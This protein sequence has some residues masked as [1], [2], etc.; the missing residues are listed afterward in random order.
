MHQAGMIA[1]L[2]QHPGHHILLADMGFV[3]VLDAD[4]RLCRQFL[5]PGTDPLAQGFGKSGLVEDADLCGIEKR[6]H[7]LGKTGSRYRAGDD[8]AVIAIQNT[9]QAIMISIRHQCGG[10]RSRTPCNPAIAATILTC[11]VP[12]SPA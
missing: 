2:D 3:D 11:L 8:D 9:V 6:R 5:G 12:A 7:A 10:H 4:T 1:A